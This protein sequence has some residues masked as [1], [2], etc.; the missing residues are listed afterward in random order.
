MAR[1]CVI[2]E[3]DLE[4]VIKIELVAQSFGW[5]RER[6]IAEVLQVII[7]SEGAAGQFERDFAS[8]FVQKFWNEY[9]R[10]SEKK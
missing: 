6:L 5:T 2:I 3:L 7:C 9:R 10:N 4:L 8:Y 1:E